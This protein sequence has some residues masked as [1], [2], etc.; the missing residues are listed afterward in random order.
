M[1]NSKK[2]TWLFNPFA[3]IA[4]WQALLIGLILILATGYIGSLSN[5]HFD[6]V[7]DTHTGRSAPLWF[8]LMTGIINWLC[9]GIV[10]WIFGKVSSKASFRAIDL[11]GTQALARWPSMLTA[12]ACL[13]PAYTRFTQTLMEFSR[14]QQMPET[15]NPM[16]A[17]VFGLVVFAMLLALCW[18]VRLMYMSYKVSCGLTKGKA[19]TTFIIG[20]ILAEILSKVALIALMAQI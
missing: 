17:V 6:G 1:N 18:M 5:T 13:A 20:L 9:M 14:T 2:S 15:F 4:G 7:L 12:L 19:I 3:Y 10:L 8:F 11:F 16:D